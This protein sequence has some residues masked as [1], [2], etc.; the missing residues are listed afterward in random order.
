M[1]IDNFIPEIWAAQL[2]TEFLASQ[3]V[4]PTVSTKFQGDATRGN[5]VK[6][7]GAV[8]P[9]IVD[10]K[11]ANRSIT[12]EALDDDGQDLLIDQEKA[13]SFLVDDID[14]VQVAGA[15]GDYTTA[16][17]Q[18]LAEDAESYILG[19]M[20]D[21]S[22]SLNVTGSTP[23]TIDSAAK[24]K[25]A[26][27]KIRTELNQKK[28]PSGNRFVVINPLFAS[29]LIEGL[30]DVSVAGGNDELRNGFIGRLF[31][32]DILESPLLGDVAKPTAIGYHSAG[33]AYVGQVNSLEALR[34]QTKFSD[35]VR[36]LTVYGCKVFR[37]E[38]TASFVSGGVEANTASTFLD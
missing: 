8:T 26:I 13:F 37:Q 1:A 11:A 36:G 34:H 33:V 23:V 7:T 19:E 21:N 15:M 20:L 30:S 35:I 4:I 28:I 31:G 17:G 5:T 32:F 16:A 24:A 3:I 10:Y 6:I 27:L 14:V 2:E 25:A 22:V 38:L 12:A 29:F 18:A 9:T